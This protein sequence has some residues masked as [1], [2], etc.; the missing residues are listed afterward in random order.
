MRKI[1][2][3]AKYACIGLE[4]LFL[5]LMWTTFL[6][7]NFIYPSQDYAV[8]IGMGS[9]LSFEMAILTGVIAAKITHMQEMGK[10]VVI[11]LEAAILHGPWVVFI[12]SL[13]LLSESTA[14]LIGMGSFLSL[15]MAV[16][17]GVITTKIKKN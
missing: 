3:Y 1:G 6:T 8:I 13:I 16:L 2:K 17:T 14:L 4:L 12:S 15:E 5:Y 7:N 9:F 11:G 10:F